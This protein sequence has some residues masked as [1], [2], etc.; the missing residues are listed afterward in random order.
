MS[1]AEPWERIVIVGSVLLSVG[2]EY[3]QTGAR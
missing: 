3:G 1:D 2:R